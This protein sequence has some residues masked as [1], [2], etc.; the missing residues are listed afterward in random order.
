MRSRHALIMRAVVAPLCALLAIAMAGLGYLNATRWKPNSQIVSQSQLDPASQYIVT[1]PGVLTMVDKNV[2]VGVTVPDAGR[3]VCIALGASRDVAGWMSGQPYT[4]VTGLQ[5]WHTLTID[6]EQAD[7]SQ[8][9]QE[10]G[11]GRVDFEDSDMW[12]NVVCGNGEV[13]LHSAATDSRQVAIVDL[14]E[15]GGSATLELHWIRGTLPDY[16]TPLYFL[17]A[18][19]ACAAILSATVFA[20]SPTARRRHRA[21]RAHVRHPQEVSLGTALAGSFSVIASNVRVPSGAS[22]RRG[23][24]KHID[25]P[26]GEETSADSSPTIVDPQA[27]NM[28]ADQQAGHAPGTGG[29]GMTLRSAASS[30]AGLASQHEGND[31]DTVSISPQELLDYL[32][33]LNAETMPSATKKEII[34]TEHHDEVSDPDDPTEGDANKVHIAQPQEVH[35][36]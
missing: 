30:S 21:S 17:A 34:A 23:V 13:S 28:L 33:R 31:D 36:S 18:L 26:A 20:M 35:Q 16:A 10:A 4:R 7:G 25:L 19:L 3:K 2:D 6:R 14:G 9:S 27:R 1:D 8:S 11:D 15:D 32:A 24:H 5:N 22:R 12:Q 29:P